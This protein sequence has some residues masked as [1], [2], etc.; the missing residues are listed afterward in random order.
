M[1][2]IVGFCILVAGNLVAGGF[3]FEAFL[4]IPTG[5][6]W[7]SSPASRSPTPTGGMIAD[8]YTAIIQM[9]LILVG[10]VG[11]LIWMAVTHGSRSPRA[12]AARPRPDDRP[13]AGR[14]HQLGDAD[15]ARHRRHRRDRLHA[16]G[17][18]RQVPGDGAAGVLRRRGR[19]VAICVPF[20]LVVLAAKAFLPADLDGPILFVLLDQYARCS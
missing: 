8:A 20:G 9:A 14:G 11:L 15:R 4:G 13:R 19:R 10:A 16:A 1:L 2:L 18:R 6:A 12:W 7:S 3:L 17:V 5:S